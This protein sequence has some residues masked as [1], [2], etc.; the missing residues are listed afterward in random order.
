MIQMTRVRLINWHNFVDETIDF[1]NITYLI[2]VNAVGKTTILDAIRYCVTT[3][4]E[5]NSAGNKKSG[6]TL[7]G[8]VHQKQRAENEYLRP[9]HTVAYIAI[10]FF[11][12][13]NNKR[14]VIAVRV[15]SE[16][17]YV[18]LKS[19][20]QDWY[21]TKPGY[22]LEDL[23]FFIDEST[24]RRPSKREEFRLDNHGMDKAPTQAEARRRI[25]RQLGIGD[26][27]AINGKKFNKVFH[28]GTSLE[29]ITD[30]RS[31]IYTYILPEPEVNID[32]LYKDMQE[33]ENLQE[34]LEE[35]KR[36]ADALK[37]I[38]DKLEKA[39]DLD[40]K[41]QS[42]ELLLRYAEYQAAIETQ[43]KLLEQIASLKL[44]L[45]IAND[46]LAKI[47]KE[48]EA[49]RKKFDDART[50]IQKNEGYT[51]LQAINGK[52]EDLSQKQNQLRD[53]AQ[54]F[55][56]SIEEL[57]AL[58]ANVNEIELLSEHV[59]I[60][61]SEDSK[62]CEEITALYNGLK[63]N[64]SLLTEKVAVLFHEKTDLENSIKQLSADI[65]TLESGKIPYPEEC[66]RVLNA[67]NIGFAERGIDETATFLCELL[68]MNETEWQDAAESYLNTQRFYI[69]VSPKN[70]YDAKEIF[71]SLGDSVKSSGLIDTV[72]LMKESKNYSA[73]EN[74]L[75]EKI[76]TENAF[77]RT[78]INYRIGDVICCNRVE[79]LEKYAKSI[80]KDRLRYQGFTL[81]RLP[82]KNL[83]IGQSA[84]ERSL[85]EYR[86][87][88]SQNSARYDS[89]CAEYSSILTLNNAYNNIINGSSLRN[90]IQYHNSREEADIVFAEIQKATKRKEEIEHSPILQA[91][92]NYE[93][94]CE[95]EYHK[96]DDRRNEKTAEIKA[97]NEK[98]DSL[99][100]E[101]ELASK[102]VEIKEKVFKDFSVEYV[103][104]VSTMKDEYE[105]LIKK[106]HTP[107]AIINNNEQQG[108]RQRK[109][110]DRD[111]YIDNELI[112]DQRRFNA[113]YN[114]DYLVG[115][116][117]KGQFITAFNSLTRIELERH[118][119]SLHEAKERCK[120]RFRK[121]VL[122]RMKADIEKAKRSFKEINR[123]MENLSYG[124]EKYRFEIDSS[125]DKDLKVF[126][127]LIMDKD[128]KQIK[129]EIDMF[130]VLDG[131]VSDVF[132]AQIEEF[133][134]RIMVEMEQNAQQVV[135]GHKVTGISMLSYADYRTYLDYDIIVSNNVT[136]KEA[137]LSKVSGD[138]SGG[139]NQAPFYVAICASLL[140]IYQQSDNSIQLVLL[141]EAFNNMT[142]DRIKPMMEMFKKLHL[143]LILIATPEKCTAIQPYCDITYSIIKQGNRN[144]VKSF[145]VV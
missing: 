19:V 139:E 3:N 30:I 132:E 18:D 118:K 52:L 106:Y 129:D 62:F 49:A 54:I 11:D 135:A 94:E 40:A 108:T 2:G 70:Y 85:K 138:G 29:E 116:E 23:P 112:P 7:Q 131:P 145:E 24:G 33:L 44:S 10:E 72:S 56:K 96:A 134:Q 65:K 89:D 74:S 82:K 110:N 25:C 93:D 137:H 136:G 140:Q 117:G 37:S 90:I 130:D 15:E 26:A 105:E 142:S 81:Q 31:F 75:A 76:G 73:K 67:I 109:K 79:D 83:C 113:E 50:N 84:I 13:L 35:S 103:S 6:R 1:S 104:F 4:K 53:Q 141:D 60:P 39:T 48:Y 12:D 99:G 88:L 143:Q 41:V 87:K 133:M 45:E 8:S 47:L 77:A 115:L 55:D 107:L 128:N 68:Y 59:I 9:G 122:F 119:N 63:A 71:V 120:E 51:E 16:S 66:L 69:L 28:M 5:F 32:D 144:T 78:Y 57:S 123:V 34:V 20:Y 36:K 121:E 111:N 100:K 58:I 42:Y 91:M 114:L 27:D 46:D 125:S 95:E 64:A 17:P 97:A 101:L 102:K 22:T 21:V 43:E 92:L 61:A 14:F 126:Y 127:S 80:T 86:I 98:L 38:V 124:E